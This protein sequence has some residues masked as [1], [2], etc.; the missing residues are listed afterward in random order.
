MSFK[1]DL[2]RPIV[3]EKPLTLGE[4]ALAALVAVVIVGA[5]AWFAF[6]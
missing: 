4:R 1:E 3:S 6:S 5:F 2:G